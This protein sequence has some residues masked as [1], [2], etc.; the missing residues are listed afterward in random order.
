MEKKMTNNATIETAKGLTFG[1]ELEYT[2][3]S[4]EKAVEKLGTK[5]RFGALSA[6]S[7]CQF[8]TLKTKSKTPH[9]YLLFRL[10]MI[11]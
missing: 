10:G 2:N 7:K 9:H 5:S 4:R 6:I 1:T 8:C 11:Y 3:I